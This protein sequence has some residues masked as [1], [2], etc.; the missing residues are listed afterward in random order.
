M[1]DLVIIGGG[2]GGYV[3]AIRAAQLGLKVSVIEKEAMGGVCLNWG[4]IPTKALLKCAETYA[5]A[6]KMSNLGIQATNIKADLKT[7]VK[8]SRD[9]SQKLSQGVSFLMRKNKV[10]VLK[11]HAT[12]KSYQSGHFQIN[13]NRQTTE[14]RNVILA[15]GASAIVPANLQRSERIWT[16]REAMLQEK[17]PK[18]LIVVGSGAIGCEFASFYQHLGTKVTLI[19]AAKHFTQC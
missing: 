19:E 9:T 12:I 14:A 16:A 2:P 1:K 8:F 10:E 3:A 18:S 6:Q 15:T 17:L 4:C 5:L 11:G 7:M 13:Y